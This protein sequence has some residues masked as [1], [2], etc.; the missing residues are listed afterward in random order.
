MG[1][2]PK[3]IQAVLEEEDENDET[4][5]EGVEGGNEGICMDREYHP[6]DDLRY[7][8]EGN[9]HHFMNLDHAEDSFEAKKRN[10]SKVRSETRNTISQSLTQAKPIDLS[11]NARTQLRALNLR[12]DSD[13]HSRP[14]KYWGKKRE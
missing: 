7:N 5:A 13:V 12:H 1:I 10:I 11:W 14:G 8:G 3:E 4:M 9:K 6:H 2:L